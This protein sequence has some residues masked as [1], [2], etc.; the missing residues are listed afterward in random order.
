MA[1]TLTTVVARGN[2][3]VVDVEATA[4]ADTTAT[5]PHGMGQTT[6]FWNVNKDRLMVMRNQCFSHSLCL[7]TVRIVM[8]WPRN[9]SPPD[10]PT[11]K[12]IRCMLAI[13]VSCGHA[14]QLGTSDQFWLSSSI[15]AKS[16]L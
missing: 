2:K 7:F 9:E 1:V 13:N 15:I 11:N 14:N 5:I 4:D 16:V 12:A 6:A 10:I 8:C 3:R